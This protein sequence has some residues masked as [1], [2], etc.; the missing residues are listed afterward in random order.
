MRVV[1]IELMY[2]ALAIAGV[3]LIT[4]GL[5]TIYKP[6]GFIFAGITMLLLAVLSTKRRA[7]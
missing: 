4:F 5:S 6:L 3:G 1:I 2:D 7:P